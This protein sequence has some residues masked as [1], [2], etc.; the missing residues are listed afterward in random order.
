MKS[1]IVFFLLLFGSLSFAQKLID[2]DSVWVFDP[3][4]IIAMMIDSSGTYTWRYMSIGALANAI[5]RIMVDEGVSDT[6]TAWKWYTAI[7]RFSHIYPT[8]DGSKL[9]GQ[10]NLRWLWNNSITV[11]TDNLVITNAGD[12]TVAI[13]MTFDGTNGTFDK[14]L[15]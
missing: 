11:Y 7:N 5:S 12:S 9:S 6:V 3:D 13:T 10:S 8:A 4:D 1:L 14:P 2:R 15:K